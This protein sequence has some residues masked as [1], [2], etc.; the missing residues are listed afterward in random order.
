MWATYKLKGSLDR[1]ANNREKEERDS[2]SLGIH[3]VFSHTPKKCLEPSK[4]TNHQNLW[5]KMYCVLWPHCPLQHCS[6]RRPA[7]TGWAPNKLL[8]SSCRHYNAVFIWFQVVIQILVFFCVISF[9]LGYHVQK[10]SCLLSWNLIVWSP[11]Y[12]AHFFGNSN[13]VLLTGVQKSVRAWHIVAHC[14]QTMIAKLIWIVTIR[15]ALV[16]S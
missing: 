16:C 12:V 11:F 4:L 2:G 14:C 15:N 13:P 7:V 6:R 3:L 9:S 1:R 5:K 8:I 10:L